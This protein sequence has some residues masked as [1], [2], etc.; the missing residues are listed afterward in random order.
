[1]RLEEEDQE[2][3]VMLERGLKK[4][5][6][7]IKGK[8]DFEFKNR[9]NKEQFKVNLSSKR[10][11]EKIEEVLE[12]KFKGEGLIDVKQVIRAGMVEVDRRNKLV[13]ITDSEKLSW[14]V[15]DHYTKDPLMD[16]EDDEKRLKKARKQA[17]ED[18]QKF[19]KEAMGKNESVRQFGGYRGGYGGGYGFGGGY[20]ASFGGGRYNGGGYNGGGYYARSKEVG[21]VCDQLE[22]LKLV[23][24]NLE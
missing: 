5:Q 15:V 14:K 11:F 20:G 6:G 4:V 1:M 19:K 17:E 21:Q 24:I 12:E 7:K 9:G 10:H 16:D 2:R 8:N 22:V 13:K 23:E 18:D 3:I